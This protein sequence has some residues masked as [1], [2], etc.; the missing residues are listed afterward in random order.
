M[1]DPRPFVVRQPSRR[2]NLRRAGAPDRRSEGDSQNLPVVIGPA[3]EL[4]AEPAPAKP[5][6]KPDAAAA[7]AAQ[8]LGQDGQKRGLRGGPETLEKA[9]ASYLGAEWSGRADRRPKAGKI[10]KTEI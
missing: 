6:A 4:P 10:T 5:S 8:I 7:F 1:S 2:R 9:R 3:N